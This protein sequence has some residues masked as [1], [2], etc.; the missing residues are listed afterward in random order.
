M[1]DKFENDS[2]D[3]IYIDG[4]HSEENVR[5]DVELYLPKLKK[6]GII[7]G[8]DYLE[9]VWPDLVNVVTDIVGKPDIV[10][11]DTSWIKFYNNKV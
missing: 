9:L 4:S 5:R 7:A 2:I 6:N 3:F 8:H 11:S 1:V 10:F